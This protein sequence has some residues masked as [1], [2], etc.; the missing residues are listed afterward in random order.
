VRYYFSRN[1]VT[2]P[3]IPGGTT[4][5]L[6]AGGDITADTAWH[7]GRQLRGDGVSNDAYLEIGFTGGKVVTTNQVIAAQAQAM[8]ADETLFSQQTHFSFD[9]DTAAHESPKLTVHYKGKRVWGRGPELDA[10]P[11]CLHEGVNLDGPALVVGGEQWLPSPASLLARYMDDGIALKPPTDEGREDMLRRG[12]FFNND[13]FT[14]PVQNGDY[15]LIVYAW[16]ANAAA[17]G[18]LEVQGEARDAF[19]CLS[20]EGGGPWAPLGPY[21]VTIDDGQLHLG[22][23]GI[24]LAGGFELR[25][26]DE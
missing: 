9:P 13:S 23:Q 14:Y 3:I 24:L 21:R 12:F 10:P 2:E 7:I 15:S 4:T 25:I 22:S 18:V 6:P 17:T 19:R 20:F 5:L 11:S 8:T 26:L 16:S 1:S